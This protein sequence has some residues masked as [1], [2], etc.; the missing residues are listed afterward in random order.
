MEPDEL[1]V[2]EPDPDPD[3][4]P[5]PDPDPD[6]DEDPPPGFEL[7]GDAELEQACSEAAAQATENQIAS[8]TPSLAPLR[9]TRIRSSDMTGPPG[10]YAA[11]RTSSQ[12]AVR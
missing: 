11:E 6:P 10:R 5:E 12:R 3:V 7:P 4:V 1:D 8:H 9:V 2:V